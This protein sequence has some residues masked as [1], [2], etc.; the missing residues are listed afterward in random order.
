MPLPTTEKLPDHP[1]FDAVSA[2]QAAEVMVS[3]QTEAIASISQV[4]PQ[5][6][7]GAGAMAN[8]IRTGRSL[9]Y[10]AAG[11][12]GLMALADASELSGTF[13]ISP[14]SIKLNMAGG[15][16]TDGHMP[17]DTEDEVADASRIA[18]GVGHGDVVIALSASG[19][20]PYPLAIAQ[21]CK[22]KGA[23]IIAITNNPNTPLLALSN[24]AICLKTP[25]EIIAGS[26]R[27]GAGTAQKVALN[28]MSSR[29]GVLLGH[30]YQ[31][32]MVNVVADNA[33]LIDRAA[34]IIARIADTSEATAKDALAQS[35]GKT[36]PAILIAAGCTPAK[37]EELLKSTGGHLGPCLET[38]KS[39]QTMT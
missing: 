17:G 18:A 16:P 1:P 33:K 5:I 8:A 35:N 34:R 38:L 39:T 23:T 15:V 2:A 29:M 12:S 19:T 13:G 36:K 32:Q 11:S 26:T 20:T 3:G 28:L 37:A 7:I 10:C 22:L 14:S 27:L 31:G 6:E 24:V 4:M 21:A 9:I 30:V 25:P